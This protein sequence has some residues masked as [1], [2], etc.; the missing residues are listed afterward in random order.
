ML[1][2]QT[3]VM[4]GGMQWMCLESYDSLHERMRDGQMKQTEDEG[5]RW[6]PPLELTLRGNDDAGDAKIL[7]AL[8]P[9]HAITA[10]FDIPA[11]DRE[12][13]EEQS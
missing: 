9:V 5:I 6:L 8:I 7:R 10:V 3:M 1:E 12:P 4:V 11:A 13:L 2:W